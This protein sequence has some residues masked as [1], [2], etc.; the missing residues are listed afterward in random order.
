ML[1]SEPSIIAAPARKPVLSASSNWI[2][3]V[4]GA[5]LAASV[6]VVAVITTPG[7]LGLDDAGQSKI[8]GSDIK[9][10]PPSNFIERPGT[11]WKNLSEPVA[12]SRLNGYLVEHSEYAAP[13]AIRGVLPYATFVSFD[14]NR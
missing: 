11:R 2:K 14:A 10:V 4:L 9:A 12:E 8:A 6:A 1:E 7:L 13:S 5:A 3:P